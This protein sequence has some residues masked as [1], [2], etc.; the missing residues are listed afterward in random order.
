MKTNILVA[1]LIGSATLAVALGYPYTDAHANV[2]YE[3]DFLSW[4]GTGLADYSAPARRNT[5]YERDFA[6]WTGTGL[7][8]GDPAV[9]APAVYAQRNPAYERD[10]AS[11]TGTGLGDVSA[12]ARQNVTYKRDL[13]VWS[14]VD[15]NKK[16]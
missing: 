10:L 9:Y 6:S 2:A 13:T 5:A 16:G 3:R 14:G 11:W 12:F 15:P 7:G 8:A 4:T 1:A